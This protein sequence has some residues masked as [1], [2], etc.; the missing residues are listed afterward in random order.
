VPEVRLKENMLYIV[1][2]ERGQIPGGETGLYDGDTRMLSQLEWLLGGESP[3]VLSTHTPEPY[4]FSQ[5]ATE[6]NLGSTQRL[7]LRRRGWLDGVCYTETVRLRP[8]DDLSAHAYWGRTLPDLHALELRLDCDFADMFEVRGLPPIDRDVRVS[9]VPDGLI[10][11]YSGQDGVPRA[12]RVVIQPMGEVIEIESSDARSNPM[13]FDTEA[14]GQVVPTAPSV[15]KRTARAIRWTLLND[16]TLEL[17]FTVTPSANGVTERGLN[18]A[19]LEKAYTDWRAQAHVMVGNRLLQRVFDRAAE[20][21][22]ALLFDTPQGAFPAAGIPWFCTPFGRDSVIVSLMTVPFY[23]QIARGTLRY[24]AAHQGKVVN[25]KNLESPGKI[26]HEQRNGEASRT[27]RTPFETYYGSVDATPLWVCLL[28]DYLEWTD[29]L[30]TVRELEPNLR[31][32]LE[33]M[34]GTDADPDG[35][36]FIEYTPH[37]GGI[38]NQVWKDSGDSTF[39]EHGQ[40]FTSNVAVVEVQAYAYRAYLSAAKV[41]RVLG[42][43]SGAAELE[44]RAERLRTKFHAAFWLEDLGTYA[45]ALDAEKNPARVIVSNPGHA[46]WAGIVPDEFAPRLADTLFSSE[47]YSGW[48][49]RTLAEGSPRFNPVSYHNGSVWPHD[50]AL[51]AL[52]LSRYGLHDHVKRL[53][54]SQLEAAALAPDARLPELFAGFKREIVTGLP[55]SPPVP[56]PAACHPQAWDA[57]APF[58][59]LW[60]ATGFVAGRAGPGLGVPD[61]WGGVTARARHHGQSFD[62]LEQNAVRSS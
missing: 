7:E 6:A 15:V 8:F 2:D 58:A 28:G 21:L 27:G 49:V 24:L 62:T 31:A 35:D 20:D 59:Y 29:D 19:A 46:L 32:A 45:H 54:Q 52:G 37:K 60:A 11:E 43:G 22:R 48:G 9:T 12:T 23:P 4:R 5:H 40:D 51:I 47:M 50:N 13:T 41:F 55:A 18:P 1:A 38:T 53:A 34:A 57:A 56:Y 44:A 3:T 17:T 26:L 39:D 14:H 36:G 61:D 30:G 25:F 42:D 10:Y 33:W 16:A